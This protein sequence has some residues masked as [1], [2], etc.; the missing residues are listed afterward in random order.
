MPLIFRHLFRFITMPLL[1]SFRFA[2]FISLYL[3]SP[4][5][6]AFSLPFRLYATLFL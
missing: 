4:L 3:F 6:P 1:L 5:L 2:A